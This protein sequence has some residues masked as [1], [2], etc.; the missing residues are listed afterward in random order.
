M[1][2][3]VADDELF[4]CWGWEGSGFAARAEALPS[5]ADGAVDVD[6]DE[7]GSARED[8]DTLLVVDGGRDKVLLPVLSGEVQEVGG[9]GEGLGCWAGGR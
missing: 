6:E 1:V 3:V 7:M 2:F 4:E 9:R 5:L 8:I